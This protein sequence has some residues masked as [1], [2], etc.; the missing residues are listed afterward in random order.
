M[1]TEYG[2]VLGEPFLHRD[3]NGN[4]C[5]LQEETMLK[6]DENGR[7]NAIHTTEKLIDPN[8]SKAKVF[9]FILSGEFRETGYKV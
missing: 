9:K 8:P 2:L 5:I 6:T 3:Y 7:V 1:T 4:Y